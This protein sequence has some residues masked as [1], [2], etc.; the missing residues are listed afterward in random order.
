MVFEDSHCLKTWFFIN[1]CIILTTPRRHFGASGG[2]MLPTKLLFGSSKR[3][4]K[5]VWKVTC[6]TNWTKSPST[7]FWHV[8]GP[9]RG[10]KS[11]VKHKEFEDSHFRYLKLFEDH[12]GAILGPS[13]FPR[14]GHVGVQKRLGHAQERKKQPRKHTENHTKK[15]HKN[16]WMHGTGSAL[17][18]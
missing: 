9:S 12:F 7:R 10:T 17:A 1:F 5:T 18:L 6:M 11:I 15:K 8:L 3:G 2:L 4:S 13:W 16:L 14:G